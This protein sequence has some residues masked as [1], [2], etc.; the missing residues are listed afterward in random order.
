MLNLAT[1]K[2]QKAE[3]K[4]EII[5]S[6]LYFCRFSPSSPIS[7]PQERTKASLISQTF[8]IFLVHRVYDGLLG[9]GLNSWKGGFCLRQ[10]SIIR[11]PDWF[12]FFK[13]FYFRSHS[14]CFAAQ[15]VSRTTNNFH[16]LY[17]IN[18]VS[19]GRKRVTQL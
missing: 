14:N 10:L 1:R 11:R 15:L 3:K 2:T 9:F 17:K 16:F 8:M 12:F 5:A 19:I 13:L 4:T 18:I 6:S 7:L